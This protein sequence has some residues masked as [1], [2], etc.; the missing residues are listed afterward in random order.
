MPARDA[1]AIAVRN[2]SR[3]VSDL[4]EADTWDK[5]STYRRMGML[6]SPS[7]H[8]N[9]LA[10]N[11]TKA[12]LDNVS[13]IPAAFADAI[14]GL[15]TGQRTKTVGSPAAYARGM[16]GTGLEEARNVLRGQA[17]ASSKYEGAEVH[18]DNVFF[19]GVRSVVFNMLEAED[20][21]FYWAAYERSIDE[22]ARAYSKSRGAGGRAEADR[23]REAPTNEMHLQA[24][25]DAERATFKS[26]NL[27]VSALERVKRGL[28]NDKDEGREARERIKE[29]RRV[30][31][32]VNP[33]DRAEVNRGSWGAMAKFGLDTLVPF[34]KVPTNVAASA[35]EYFP[36]S[37]A[38]AGGPIPFAAAYRA[39]SR[40]LS[41]PEQRLLSEMVGRNLLGGGLI[42]LGWI[43]YANGWGKGSVPA[44]PAGTTERDRMALTGQLEGSIRIGGEWVQVS[45]LGPGASLFNL[46]ATVAEMADREA[47][48]RGQ[49]SLAERVVDAVQEIGRGMTEGTFVGTI[50]EAVDLASN[51]TDKRLGQLVG[52]QV[53]SF[54]PGSAPLGAVARGL[55]PVERDLGGEGFADAALNQVKSRIPGLRQR[56]PEK[57]TPL[58]EPEASGRGGLGGVVD[59]LVNPMRH[60]DVQTMAAAAE[61]AR[62][63]VRVGRPS[64]TFTTAGIERTLDRTGHDAY[65]REEG[66]AIRRLVDENLKNPDYL[67]MSDEQKRQ[68]LES[69]IRATKLAWSARKA[70]HYRNPQGMR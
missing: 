14:F 33:R 40:Q 64:R 12:A 28:E 15:L 30:G 10:G 51:P 29:A 5:V 43:A 27:A 20:Q 38:F 57:L 2:M 7:T 39:A 66:A 50:G 21:L 9:N 37:F 23:L 70:A 26:D 42:A 18:F 46:G 6:M 17:P 24:A 11:L 59:A 69:A 58:G 55:D 4:K 22:Q 56:L 52:Q 62:L 31:A 34:A 68:T 63:G 53:A 60:R 48:K 19:E 45:R 67:R 47:Q 13:D 3:F 25:I 8:F 44:G 32:P 49:P 35:L 41:V 61:I 36:G 65:R 16:K 1:C 54:L